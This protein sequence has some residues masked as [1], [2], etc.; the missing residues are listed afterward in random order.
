MK[1]K[2]QPT[3]GRISPNSLDMERSAM[4]C[5]L[6]DSK[7]GFAK[8]RN[9]LPSSSAFYDHKH[10]LLYKAMQSLFESGDPIDVRTVCEALDRSEDLDRAGG[11]AYLAQLSRLEATSYHVEA[12]A[13]AVKESWLLREIITVAQ[14]ITERAYD[15]GEAKELVAD[16]IMNMSNV[17]S[18]VESTHIIDAAAA[19][20]PLLVRLE[21]ELKD[22]SRRRAISTGFTGLDYKFGGF[23]S[24]DLV[25]VMG[26]P[27]MGKSAFMVNLALSAS[28]TA[29]VAIFSLESSS[30]HLL[31]RV[32]SNMTGIDS[33][34]IWQGERD[35]I[36]REFWDNGIGK[37]KILIDERS[38]YN[39]IDIRA[40]VASLIARY[41]IKVVFIDHLQLVNYHSKHDGDTENKKASCREAKR[42]AKDYGITVVLLNQLDKES[43]LR[44]RPRGASA[45]YV[46]SDDP[47][48]IV[49][50]WR[51]DHEQ[52]IVEK[53]TLELIV[54][55]ARD[56][57]L[58]TVNTT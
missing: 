44:G 7:L 4:S 49:G 37:R 57:S 12:Y 58:G 51:D 19:V 50:L 18:N 34:R 6:V 36:G 3:L 35:A 28:N 46:G 26:A 21:E 52:E 41:N 16:L 27:S 53:S 42:I 9:I 24:G 13:R 56:G 23:R 30:D 55:K 20:F 15:L 45:R 11:E 39:M 10:V 22:P 2:Q 1:P 14:T 47:D 54:L 5:C 33:K 40:R 48:V 43:I 38:G 17:L 25:M 32:I 8:M 29:P 31:V